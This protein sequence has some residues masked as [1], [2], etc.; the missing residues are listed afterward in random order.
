MKAAC[1]GIGLDVS[2]VVSSQVDTAR[3]W[4][5]PEGYGSAGYWRPVDLDF[6]SG[7]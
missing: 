5:V 2:S 7:I 6:G 1:V 4:S 3:F